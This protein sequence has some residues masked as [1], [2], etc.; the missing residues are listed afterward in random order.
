MKSSQNCGIWLLIVALTS[1]ESLKESDMIIFRCPNLSLSLLGKGAPGMI[2]F[3][4]SSVN[5]P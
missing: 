5:K 2:K 3:N 4:F 1:T